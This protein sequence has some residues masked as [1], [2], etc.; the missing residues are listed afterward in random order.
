MNGPLVS[1]IIPTYNR[2]GMLR[3][4]VHSV[5][6]QT[7]SAFELIVVDDGSVEDLT[8]VKGLVEDSGGQFFRIARSGVSASR[9][10]GVRLSK[11]EWIAFL[12]SDDEWKADKLSKQMTFHKLK[13][14]Y[15]ISQTEDIWIR[16]GKQLNKKLKYY[17]PG[18]DIF[19]NCLSL[20]CINPSAVVLNHKVL[21]RVGVFDEGL[22]VCEDYDLWL[23]I[24]KDFLV[25]LIPEP[26]VVKYGGHSD[27]LSKQFP[28]MDRFRLYSLIKLYCLN[29]LNFEK[30]DLLRKEIFVKLKILQTGSAKRN[31]KLN[32]LCQRIAVAME[33]NDDIEALRVLKSKLIDLCYPQNNEEVLENNLILN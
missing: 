8:L 22:P 14:E 18:G 13:P 9:N 10:L 3:R 2:S 21:E 4:A 20:C 23:R 31:L 27:Q 33:K 1:V 12:D 11:G 5:L 6:A 25:G 30:K 16:N 29:S 15:L 32:L 24:S 26:L 19:S 28:A 17:A 7:Y